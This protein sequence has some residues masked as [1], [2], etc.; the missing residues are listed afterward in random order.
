VVPAQIAA[1]RH[2]R[3]APAHERGHE[4]GE[5]LTDD[6]LA[7]PEQ[8]VR[9]PALRNAAALLRVVREHVAVD[10][11]HALEMLRQHA[12][13]EQSRDARADDDRLA[14]AKPFRHGVETP[15]MRGHSL[16]ARPP[17]KQSVKAESTPH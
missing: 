14:V 16:P 12:S 17:G 4:I 9:V 2:R 6:L 7:A 10:D 11:R 1:E 8:R 13:R 5:Q 3:G 15:S